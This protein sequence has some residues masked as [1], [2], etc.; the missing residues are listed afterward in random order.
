MR[1]SRCQPSSRTKGLPELARTFQV[2]A[3]ARPGWC[4]VSNDFDLA[5]L[6][7]DRY[8]RPGDRKHFRDGLR[9]AGLGRSNYRA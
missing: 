8:R 9:K 1:E 4:G 2:R 6:R 3:S 5:T 7:A